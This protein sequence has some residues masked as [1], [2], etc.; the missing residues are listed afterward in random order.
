VVLFRPDVLDL[1]QAG[2]PLRMGS[3]SPRRTLHVGDFLREA[4]PVA[5][6][7]LEFRP[8]RGP[9]E[10]RLRRVQLPRRE[11]HA[12]DAV[13]LALAGIARLWGDR[14]GHT[15]LA[16]LLADT[17]LMALPLGECPTAPGQG[18][19]A[20]ECR[21]DD[22]VTTG[23]LAALDDAA[24]RR[25]V[26]RELALL[27]AQ[28]DEAQ[29]SFSATSVHHEHCGTLV[30][31]RGR[32]GR[33]PQRALAWKRPPSPGAVQSWDGGDWIHASRDLP[34]AP[35]ALGQPPAIFVAHA[36]AI[37]PGLRVPADA[38]LW[39]SGV[40]SWRR[41]AR[42]GLWVEGCA[43]NLGF[44]FVV[45]TLCSP[46]LRLP[47]LGEWTALTR[48][49]AVSSWAG[50]GIGRVVPTYVVEPPDDDEVLDGIRNQVRTA[51]HFYWGSAAQFRAVRDWLPAHSHHACGPGKTYRALREAG[52]RKLQAFPS[53]SEWRAWVA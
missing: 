23:V 28:P 3:S 2:E 26:Q 29:P 19:L 43:D 17:R 13:I 9:V 11:P 30:F 39:V 33:G 38:R 4:L 24:T 45:P 41:L 12:L 10:D 42:Q 18:A 22:A 37:T 20:V 31:M 35:P 27:A 46:V 32:A 49:D 6:A 8:L 47:P 15:A 5:G 25:R 51:T 44:A 40:E 50:S 52:V 36:R 1:L 53:R 7:A 16:P 48:E 34:L 14:E 21:S